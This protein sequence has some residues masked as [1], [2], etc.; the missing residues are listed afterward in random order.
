MEFEIKM[1]AEVYDTIDT[2]MRNIKELNDGDEI[3]GWLLG[4]W[5][6]DDDEEETK[7]TLILNEFIIPQQEVSGGEVNI[8]PSSMTDMIKEF[9]SEK[10]NKV[11]AH[12]HIHPF[13]SGKT[14][15]SG[16]DEEKI[17][18]FME[19]TKGREI[20][21]FLL[22]S[23]D[24]I[25]AR[26]ELNTKTTILGKTFNI[27]KSY[28]NLDIERENNNDTTVFNTLKERIKLKVSRTTAFSGKDWR[29]Y[30]NNLYKYG[31][32]GEYGGYDQY[33]NWNEEPN[34]DEEK[35]KPEQELWSVK[36]N[37]KLVLLKTDIKFGEFMLGC[38]YADDDV[39]KYDNLVIENGNYRISYLFQDKKTAAKFEE[40]LK[41]ELGLI[42]EEYMTNLSEEEASVIDYSDFY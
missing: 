38:T 30:S 29:N 15:W 17:R 36:R 7:A 3:G 41:S 35:E 1:K 42:E 12:W 2:L 20:F 14:D 25:K 39:S 33:G 4:D 5:T 19:P 10:C 31:E 37:K 28:D 21:V 13:G 22:S 11:K 16:V 34:K 40:L 18:D 24:R 32:Y 23:E 26:V 6:I 8:E 27:K 9:G